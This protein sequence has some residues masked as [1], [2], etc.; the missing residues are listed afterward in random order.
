MA[1]E[2]A[3]IVHSRKDLNAKVKCTKVVMKAKYNYRMA[4]QGG[5]GD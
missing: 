3:K 4:I 2:R 5:Q 1:N